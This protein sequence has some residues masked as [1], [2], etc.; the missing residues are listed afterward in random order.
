MI[1]IYLG[2]CICSFRGYFQLF[3]FGLF[4]SSP[5]RLLYTFAHWGHTNFHY[6]EI[7]KQ[8]SLI[9][10]VSGISRI[11]TQLA[12]NPPQKINVVETAKVARGIPSW[13]PTETGTA[14]SHLRDDV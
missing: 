10:G 13:R 3:N 2:K 8:S 4:F 6:S 9:F 14:T 5:G 1:V 12:W 7:Y 11:S